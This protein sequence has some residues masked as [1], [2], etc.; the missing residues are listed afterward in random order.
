MIPINKLKIFC[1]NF[2]MGYKISYK[3]SV[4]FFNVINAEELH[5]F[6]DAVLGNFLRVNGKPKVFLYEKVKLKSYTAINGYGKLVINENTVVNSAYFDLASF[7]NIGKNVVIG[8]KGTEF[9][10]HGYDINRNKLIGG[11]TIGD[12]TYIGSR[13]IFN[14]GISVAANVSIGAGT[15]VSKT[16]K[17]SFQF[18]VSNQIVCKKAKEVSVSNNYHY[19][20]IINGEKVFSKNMKE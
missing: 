19:L 17:E 15:V 8:G 10:T 13:V 18:I 16:I 20:G 14:L 6:D 11:I 7:I 2:F 1:Y 4:G 3:A 9:W 12:N 5:V